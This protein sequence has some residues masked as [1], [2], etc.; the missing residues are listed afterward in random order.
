MEGREGGREGKE[1]ERE[2]EREKVREEERKGAREGERNRGREE[3]KEGWWGEGK[4]TLVGVHEEVC[5]WHVCNI[6]PITFRM[7]CVLIIFPRQKALEG[8]HI[9]KNTLW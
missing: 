2:G 8:Y 9:S 5:A 1:G 4:P 7:M 3:A 6:Y